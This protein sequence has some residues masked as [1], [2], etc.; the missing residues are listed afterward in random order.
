[1]N[2]KQFYTNVDKARN[3][4]DKMIDFAN[5]SNITEEYLTTIVNVFGS[6]IDACKE[7][8]KRV[9]AVQSI[10]NG[11]RVRLNF[12]DVSWELLNE[13]DGAYVKEDDGAIC[14][15]D[16]LEVATCLGEQDYEYYNLTNV[17]N[18]KRYYAL[19]GYHLTL[20]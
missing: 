19:S 3:L 13:C 10:P 1:M 16:S 4:M 11:R 20:I 12:K 14:T 18:K 7:R 17:K 9:S 2:G 8:L 6:K 15:V 5:D